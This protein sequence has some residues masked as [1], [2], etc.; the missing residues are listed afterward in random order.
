MNE[1]PCLCKRFG[2]DVGPKAMNLPVPCVAFKAARIY[3]KAPDT[4]LSNAERQLE[5]M[6]D[7]LEPIVAVLQCSLIVPPLGEQGGEYQRVD[8]D[9]QQCGTRSIS[10]IGQ[11]REL[12]QVARAEGGSPHDGATKNKCGG[13]GKHRPA[14]R[15][16]QRR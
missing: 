3:I 15:S 6:I 2:R 13:S 10:A 11:A 14:M 9:G 1:T 12:A 4:E 8:R 7:T 16:K 5:P